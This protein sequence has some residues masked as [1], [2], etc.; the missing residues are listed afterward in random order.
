MF[1]WTYLYRAVDKLGK[2]VNFLLTTKR[3]LAAAK[4]FLTRALC[5]ND[6]PEKIVMDKSGA[7]KAAIDAVNAGRSVSIL[8][9]QVKYLNN[10]VEQDHHVIERVTKPMLNIKLSPPP[11]R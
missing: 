2:A 6:Y 1:V 9:R 3:D 11:A 10:I 7:N 5:A 4:R 8:M